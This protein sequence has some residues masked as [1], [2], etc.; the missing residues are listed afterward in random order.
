MGDDTLQGW[1]LYKGL[2]KKAG[3]W[4][5]DLVRFLCIVTRARVGKRPTCPNLLLLLP[6]RLLCEIVQRTE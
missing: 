3:T 4:D 2:G 1:T 5:V 6:S